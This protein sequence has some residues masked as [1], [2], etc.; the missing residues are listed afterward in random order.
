MS[1]QKDSGA[2]E[3]NL[4]AA[5]SLNK[6]LEKVNESSLPDF[7]TPESMKEQTIDKS[8]GGVEAHYSTGAM[9]MSFT[10]S[11]MPLQ[12]KTI[13][14]KYD[15]LE[16]LFLSMRDIV[17]KKDAGKALVM[18]STNFGD[19]YFELYVNKCPK[20]CYNFIELAKKGNLHQS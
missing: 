11:S 8:A 2:G 1:A 5:G 7:A 12:T 10:S 14:H 6:V 3:V 9:S 19:M 15:A 16:A 4:L 18:M 13:A 17:D 20:T